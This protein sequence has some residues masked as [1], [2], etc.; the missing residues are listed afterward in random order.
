MRR[1]WLLQLLYIF[2]KGSVKRFRLVYSGFEPCKSCVY[3]YDDLHRIY[4]SELNQTTT[5]TYPMSRLEAGSVVGFSLV[6]TLYPN[7]KP[8]VVS[9]VV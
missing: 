9:P 2:Q 1:G 4:T 5:Q 3:N 8:F 6:N 7:L